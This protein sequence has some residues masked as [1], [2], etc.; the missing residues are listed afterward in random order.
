MHS[1]E[2]GVSAKTINGVD[3]AAINSVLNWRSIKTS[4]HQPRKPGQAQGSHKGPITASRRRTT[5]NDW[6]ARTILQHALNAASGSPKGAPKLIAAKRWVPW[7][8]AYTGAR[9]GEI[10]Q[11][12][13]CDVGDFDGHP[14]IAI[15]MDAGTVKTKSAWHVPLHPHLIEQGFIEFVNGA[16]T[17]TSFLH[18]D[19]TSIGLMRKQVVLKTI[20]AFLARCKA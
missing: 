2:D 15:S 8:M 6:E 3:L 5:L 12:R 16:E 4:S 20:A 19:R 14:A 13:K 10:A 7:L 17:G 9:V 1:N 11:L 18:R